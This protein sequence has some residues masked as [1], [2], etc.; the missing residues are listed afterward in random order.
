MNM[1]KF[2]KNLMGEIANNGKFLVGYVITQ[3]PGL[4]SFPGLTT[5]LNTALV[6][7]TPASYVDLVGQLLLAVAAMHR[8]GKVVVKAA[9]TN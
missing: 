8:A 1:R 5:A 6:D 2:V 4:T 7:R 9:S 3:V